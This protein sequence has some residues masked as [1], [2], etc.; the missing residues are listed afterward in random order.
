LGVD[1]DE[2]SSTFEKWSVPVVLKNK[3]VF[4]DGWVDANSP[5]YASSAFLIY[6]DGRVYAALIKKNTQHIN[7]YTND[8]VSGVNPAFIAWGNRFAYKPNFYNTDGQL[9]SSLQKQPLNSAG[10]ITHQ[11]TT[12]LMSMTVEEQ[13]NLRSVSSEI[14]NSSVTAA[15][16]MNSD[17]GD[18]VALATAD[19][20]SCSLAYSLVPNP[21]NFIASWKYIVKQSI[22]II[23]YLSGLKSSR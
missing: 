13:E 17:L 12:D 5:I 4:F 22:P 2:F 11:A 3:G 20:L 19:I 9:I 1:F 16:D 23:Q 14:W 6:P 8:K 10:N 18:Q 21:L 7:Y 15:W